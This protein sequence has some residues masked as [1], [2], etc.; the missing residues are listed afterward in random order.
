MLR[1]Q[2]LSLVAMWLLIG[3]VGL[4]GA[5]AAA[6]WLDSKTHF[7]QLN[8]GHLPLHFRGYTNDQGTGRMA[9]FEMENKS[10]WKVELW[11]A[12]YFIVRDADQRQRQEEID[13]APAA[14]D[15]GAAATISVRP[16]GTGEWQVA[17]RVAKLGTRKGT[18]VFSEWIDAAGSGE[19]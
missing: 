16:P 11:P 8:P 7:R 1:V 10:D 13:I 12:A 6:W 9:L 14:I 3:V 17:F 18:L 19:E 5:L 4:S 2:R 15:K